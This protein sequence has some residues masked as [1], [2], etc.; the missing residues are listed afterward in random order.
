MGARTGRSSRVVK[1]SLAIIVLVLALRLPFLHQAIQGD[2]LYYLYGAEHAQIEPLHPDHAKYLFQGD[3]VDMRGHSHPPLD[4]WIL[5]ALLWACGDVREVPFHLAYSMFSIIAALAMLSLA[6]RFCDRPFLATL[7]FIAVPAFVVNGNSLETDLPFLALW[8]LV[9]AWFVKGVEENSSFALIGSA[10]A[11]GVAAL[12]AY[13]AVFIVP[14]LGFYLWQKSNRRILAWSV[15]FAAPIVIGAWQV[16]GRIAGGAMPAMVLWDYMRQYGWQVLAQKGKN[17]GALIVHSAWILSPLLIRGNRWNWILGAVAGAGGA[18]YDP[19]PM[20]WVSFGLGVVLLSSCVRWGFLEAWVLIFFAAGLVVFFAGSARYLLPIAAP[21]AILA[22][23]RCSTPMIGIGF[24][25]QMA[26]SVG[27]AIVNYQT[28]AAY[29]Q[30]AISLAP[31]AAQTR[32]W[33][34]HDWGLR[35]YLE[36]EGALAVPRVQTFSV[37]DVVVS[38]HPHP[39]GQVI[40]SLE[41]RPWIPLRLFSVN[42]K[43]AYSLAQKS[44]WPFE[45]STAPVDRVAA[46]LIGE[47]K[48]ELSW[49]S[50]QDQQQVLRGLSPDGW[51]AAEATVLVKHANGPLTA[52]FTIHPQSAARHV[53]LLVDGRLVAEESFPAPGSYA[54][55]VPA[56]GGGSAITVTLGVDKTFSVPGDGRQLGVLV[57]GIGF[58]P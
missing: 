57:T 43:S 54:L 32:V 26:L 17:A 7:L 15:I 36:S 8:M 10:L 18:L 42:N 52:E 33:I 14:I 1:E 27:F 22:V 49:V 53:Q 20:F 4:S 44:L 39:E 34:D 55:S 6:R 48:A 23:M 19:N 29:R 46:Y 37:G 16:Y 31:E 45:I 56:P 41:I 2:D 11:A 13:Q 24:A 21:L 28:W 3:L 25:L 38:N 58:K 40:A 30:F 35:Y 50:P 5:G 47:R 51:T 9:I 12:D